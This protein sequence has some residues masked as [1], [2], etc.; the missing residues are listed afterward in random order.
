MIDKALL[1]FS[2]V[3][4]LLAL[5]SNLFL[6]FSSDLTRETTLSSILS[7]TKFFKND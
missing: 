3:S 7:G 6:L 4:E 1:I 5:L 2:L